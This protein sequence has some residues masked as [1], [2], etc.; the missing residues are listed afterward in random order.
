MQLNPDTISILKEWKEDE[1]QRSCSPNKRKI[2]NH[3][4]QHIS[5]QSPRDSVDTRD[6]A[7]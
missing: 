2:V 4:L 7:R 6:P 3:H 5:K 1:T